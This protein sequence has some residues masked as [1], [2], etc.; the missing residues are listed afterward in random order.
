MKENHLSGLC[1]CA[2]KSPT[3]Q[4][5][6]QGQDL[7]KVKRRKILSNIFISDLPSQKNSQE[8]FQSG[9]N[10]TLTNSFYLSVFTPAEI[11]LELTKKLSPG[12]DLVI[13]HAITKDS[14]FSKSP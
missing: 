14:S 4:R 5:Q 3:L 8:P 10:Q 2:L 13:S 1:P 9:I 7:G 6:K 11:V 12:K